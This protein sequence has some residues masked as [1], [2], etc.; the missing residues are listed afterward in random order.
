MLPDFG[1]YREDRPSDFYLAGKLWGGIPG[2][3]LLRAAG[4]G[5][6]WLKG[7]AATA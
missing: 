3:L 7:R 2:I 1:A 5:I 6:W 4:A